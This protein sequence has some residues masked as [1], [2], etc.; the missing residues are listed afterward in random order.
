MYTVPSSFL[1]DAQKFDD[2]GVAG[3]MVSAH[4]ILDDGE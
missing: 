1:N 4:G 3:D 2:I